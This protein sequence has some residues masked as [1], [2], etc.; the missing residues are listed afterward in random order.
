MFQAFFLKVEIKF[1]LQKIHA[2]QV[3]AEIMAHA[4]QMALFLHLIV[5]ALLATMGSHVNMVGGLF[6]SFVSL[7]LNFPFVHHKDIFIPIHFF[8]SCDRINFGPLYED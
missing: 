7:L 1:L 6:F 2:I 5:H 4:S 3:H 8:F